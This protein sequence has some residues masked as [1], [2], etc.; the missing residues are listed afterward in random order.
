MLAYA[1]MNGRLDIIQAVLNLGFT[2]S[3]DGIHWSPLHWAYRLA[4]L[5]VIELLTKNGIRS[6]CI[7]TPEGKWSPL[8][9][10]TFYGTADK[11]E[12]LALSCKALLGTQNDVNRISTKTL[13]GYTCDGCFLVSER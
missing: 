13:N 3:P 6:D 5:K 12:N 1:V 9:I 8:D 4:N 11:L 7:T 10:A 2:F